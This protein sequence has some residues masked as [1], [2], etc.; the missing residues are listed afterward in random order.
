MS[1][2]RFQLNVLA[3]AVN[4]LASRHSSHDSMAHYRGICSIDDGSE[5]TPGGA[6]EAAADAGPGEAAAD[7]GP[8][9]AAA[10]AGPGEAAADAGPGEAA[11]DAGPGEAA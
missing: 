8:G 10:D 2:S 7:A 3:L 1:R 4:V 9:E 11:A 6:G 5:Q